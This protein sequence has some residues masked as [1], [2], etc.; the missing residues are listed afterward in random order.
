MTD[1]RLW[2]DLETDAERVE[3][4]LSG[5]A[6][7]TGV[8]APAMVGEIVTLYRRIQA[9]NDRADEIYRGGQ[10]DKCDAAASVISAMDEVIETKWT[11]PE[12]LKEIP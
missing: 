10:D 2:C 3:F 1:N 4:L 6:C 8:I 12:E 7:D 5:R 9:A 11:Y